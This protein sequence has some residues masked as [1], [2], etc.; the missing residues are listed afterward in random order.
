MN[1]KIRPL[2][3][4]YMPGLSFTYRATIQFRSRLF[5]PPYLGIQFPGPELLLNSGPIPGP[6]IFGMVVAGPGSLFRHM[7]PFFLFSLDFILV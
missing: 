6:D 1:R 2:I 5:Y 7:G 4:A 3:G